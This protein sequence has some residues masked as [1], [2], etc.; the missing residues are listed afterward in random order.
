[1]LLAL[2]YPKRFSWRLL[3][4]LAVGALLPFVLQ[5]AD[6]VRE[7]YRVWAHYLV[8]EDRQ[9]GPIAD[10]YRDLRALWRVYVAPMSLERYELVEIIAAAMIAGVAL[11]G[12]G[13]RWPQ[14]VLL[15][16]VLSLACCWMT[17]LGPAT[18]SATYI[19]LAPAAAWMLVVS[20]AAPRERVWRIAYGIVF[21]LLVASQ[22]ALW[23]GERGR[24]FRDRLQPF[25]LAGTLL[26][27]LLLMDALRTRN[28]ETK[29]SQG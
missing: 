1:M 6:Y 28:T 4:C 7:Q 12:Q 9:R 24:W 14:N 5:H 17:A 2:L 26:F 29:N 3:V 13:R 20:E 11:L 15:A 18:E 23:F 21:G 27:V 16:F 25:P 22:C 19:L 10:W 8:T